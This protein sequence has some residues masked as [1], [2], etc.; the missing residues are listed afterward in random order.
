MGALALVVVACGGTGGGKVTA[1][2][3]GSPG[4]AGTSAP[5]DGGTTDAGKT[6]AGPVDSG[7]GAAPT[8]AGPSDAGAQGLDGGAPDGGQ[9]DAGTPDGGRP[10]DGG[11]LAC[12]PASEPPLASCDVLMPSL[13]LGAP[14]RFLGP[15][16]ASPG[17]PIC[18]PG[19]FSG[20]R[21]GLLGVM[22]TLAEDQNGRVSK[23]ELDLLS[24]DGTLL[25]GPEEAT[26]PFAF[27]VPLMQGAGVLRTDR[28]AQGTLVQIDSTGT[29]SEVAAGMARSA[30]AMP[31]GGTVVAEGGTLYT[32][33]GR[34]LT[35]P[36]K[37]TRRDDAGTTLWS[38]PIPPSIASSPSDAQ[39]YPNGAG[40]VLA[41]VAL[42]EYQ[43][44]LV[45]LDE[46]GRIASSSDPQGAFSSRAAAGPSLELP[47]HSLA[48]DVSPAHSSGGW[49]VIH[50]LDASL[51]VPPCWLDQR[52]ETRVFPIRGGRGYAVIHG[53][54][55]AGNE[56]R[57]GLEIV[58]SNGESCGWI[59][60]TCGD[61][62]PGA[63]DLSFANVGLDGTLYLN[64]VS[65]RSPEQCLV[66]SWPALLR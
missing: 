62:T 42:D 63:C 1:S 51:D 31:G 5:T 22:R 8:D 49:V 65:Q 3:A 32:M 47:D 20:D 16:L 59:D 21:D 11:A 25:R 12:V 27:V 39:V 64:G 43:V 37:I 36:L 33:D 40:H 15:A 46:Q 54:T 30:S 35:A 52:R 66:E 60:A 55:L 28:D 53:T 6:D 13:P 56:G 4:E 10:P 41:A 61:P 18:L 23:F 38:T 19:A 24:P 26:S 50:D 34:T 57:Q 2:S 45:W 58:A 29:T 48:F 7:T 44:L 17:D 14:R 9:V